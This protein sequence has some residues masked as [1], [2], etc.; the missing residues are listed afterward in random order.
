MVFPRFTKPGLFPDYH[1]QI[2]E[3]PIIFNNTEREA[4]ISFIDPLF[5][6][7]YFKR[8]F[9]THYAPLKINTCTHFEGGYIDIDTMYIL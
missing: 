2:W 1:Q 7:N 5:F 8:F 3:P 6:Y 4:L 9:L